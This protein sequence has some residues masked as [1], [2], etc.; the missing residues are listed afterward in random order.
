[1][2]TSKTIV[3]HLVSIIIETDLSCHQLQLPLTEEVT[4][5][6]ELE[7]IVDTI[8][9]SLDSIQQGNTAVDNVFFIGGPGV[10]EQAKQ[11]SSIA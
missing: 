8:I 4:L 7:K 6:R 9:S 2:C 5:T 3:L 11:P 10:E 1:M